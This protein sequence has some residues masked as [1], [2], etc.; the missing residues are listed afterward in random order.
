MRKRSNKYVIINLAASVAREK[1]KELWEKQK[2]FSLR[3][4]QVVGK[5]SDLRKWCPVVT[6]FY[7]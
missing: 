1:N 7:K 2:G 4:G 3:L 6:V 5:H